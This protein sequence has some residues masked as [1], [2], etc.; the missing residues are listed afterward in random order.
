MKTRLYLLLL[1]LLIIR[2]AFSQVRV[3]DSDKPISS[4]EISYSADNNLIIVLVLNSKEN[5][6]TVTATSSVNFKATI[7]GQISWNNT[8][9]DPSEKFV[10]GTFLATSAQTPFKYSADIKYGSSLKFVPTPT[11]TPTSRNWKSIEYVKIKY[12]LDGKYNELPFFTIF[13][14]T[15]SINTINNAIK[16]AGRGKFTSKRTGE[17]SIES[18]PIGTAFEVT[19]CEIV[20]MLG[21][22]EVVTKLNSTELGASRYANNGKID[23][24]FTIGSDID[25]VNASFKAKVVVKLIGTAEVI[26]SS[27]TEVV[28][29]DET[30]LIIWNRPP[31]YSITINDKDDYSDS[32]INVSGKGDLNIEFATKDYADLIRVTKS[33]IGN[34]YSFK[35]SGLN[36]I[37]DKTYSYFYYT[38]NGERISPPYLI[39]KEAPVL[40]DFQFIGISSKSISMEF[41]LP[42]F[43]NEQ[44]VN[45][46]VISN[47]GKDL[48][49]GGGIVIKRD[50]TD[51]TKFI[52]NLPNSITDLIVKDTIRDLRFSIN[53]NSKKLYSF[54]VKVFNQ[55]LLNDKVAEL[56]AATADKPNKRNRDEIKKTV[57]SIVKIGEAVGNSIDDKEVGKAIDDLKNGDKEKIKNVMADIG[58]WA[59]IVGKVVL[60]IL[61]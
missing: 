8:P 19:Q 9:S 43:V 56:I 52:V 57:E 53:Y 44:L 30:P 54:G 58:K 17:I 25:E 37:P 16:I 46:N 10:S 22:K 33:K 59:L 5:T 1:T 50:D 49:I 14:P 3:V 60:P 21:G 47:D 26:T 51:K 7:E 42:Q 24:K 35:L 55:K 15:T 12:E 34:S 29:V 18:E 32:E 38:S 31:S 6:Q 36:Q 48:V 45:V 39:V 28:F 20:K 13:P 23:L 11:P 41:R 40:T 61:V 27:Y 4:I 2:P